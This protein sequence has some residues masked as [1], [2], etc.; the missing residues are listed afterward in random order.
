[1]HEELLAQIE[2][3]IC[4]QTGVLVRAAGGRPDDLARALTWGEK[5]KKK[6]DL[7]TNDYVVWWYVLPLP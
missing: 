4:L 5:T 2:R 7:I 3:P 1:M 6:T